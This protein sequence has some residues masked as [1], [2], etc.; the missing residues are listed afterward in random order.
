MM[1][2]TVVFRTSGVS[3]DFFVA[4]LY[5][6]WFVGPPD[7]LAGARFWAHAALNE[8]INTENSVA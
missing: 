2:D 7:R 3:I 5:D 6:F 4:S 8:P 1:G